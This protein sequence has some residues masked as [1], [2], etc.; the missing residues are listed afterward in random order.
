[1]DNI[2]ELKKINKSYGAKKVLCDL[3][4]A[5]KRGEI[6][7]LVGD[8]GAGKTTLMRIA[9]K[10]LSANDGEIKLNLKKAGNIG[11]HIENPMLD[12]DLTV[13][14]NLEAYCILCGYNL[15][16]VN[17]TI[18]QFNIN[19]AEKKVK[20]LNLGAKQLT[21]LAQAFM[22]EPEFIILDEPMNGLDPK[23]VKH[24]REKILQSNSKHGITFLISSHLIDELAKVVTRC[25]M[26]KDGKIN[27]IEPDAIEEAF[28][29]YP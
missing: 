13:R 6:C 5:V 26:L 17:E 12:S 25:A 3:D 8:N 22:G 9:L 7:G 19:F 16:L 27:F 18:E 1:M 15:S 21:A 2:L 24:I 28:E 14:Q 29:V 4:F 11:I 10:L 23:V 20:Q